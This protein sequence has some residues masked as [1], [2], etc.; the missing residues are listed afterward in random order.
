MPLVP[1]SFSPWLTQCWSESTEQMRNHRCGWWGKRLG[2]QWMSQRPR[3]S[4]GHAHQGQCKLGH[5]WW[6]QLQSWCYRRWFR[7]QWCWRQYLRVEKLDAD[8]HKLLA[9]KVALSSASYT[10]TKMTFWAVGYRKKKKREKRC[11]I[12]NLFLFVLVVV[13]LSLL[14]RDDHI[15]WF[16]LLNFLCSSYSK[17]FDVEA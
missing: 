4:Q 17:S 9:S 13:V 7:H 8:I 1:P 14:W 12:Y 11:E 3:S 10:Y 6:Y 16:K 5:Q 2:S 15:D